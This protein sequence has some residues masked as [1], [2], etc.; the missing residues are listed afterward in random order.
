M[1]ARQSLRI[2]L[3]ATVV[4]ASGACGPGTAPPGQPPMAQI[5]RDSIEGFREAFNKTSDQARVVLLL[6]PT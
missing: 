3:V 4:A 2:L 1:M 5:T 6:S